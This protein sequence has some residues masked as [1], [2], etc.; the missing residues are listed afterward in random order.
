MPSRG[1]QRLPTATAA[2]QAEVGTSDVG[3]GWWQLQLVQ[4]CNVQ[5]AQARLRERTGRLLAFR[6]RRRPSAALITGWCR[7]AARDRRGRLAEAM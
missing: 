5:M 2:A 3:R 6:W 1:W 7:V 4:R